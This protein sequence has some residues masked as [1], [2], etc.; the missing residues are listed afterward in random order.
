MTKKDRRLNLAVMAMGLLLWGCSGARLMMPTPNVYLNDELEFFQ[1]L[2]PELKSTQVKLFYMTDRKPEKDNKGTLRYGYGRSS[3]LAF[4]TTVVDLGR[5]MTWEEL[6]QASRTQ[7]RSKPVKLSLLDVTELI[8]GPD[9]PVPYALIDGKVV[10][11][12]ALLAQREEAI[13]AIR[14]L[15]VQQLA[16]TPRKEVFIYIH[17]YHNNFDKAAFAMAELWHF[18]GRIGVPIVYTWPSGYPGLFGYTYDRESS[19]FTIYHLRE[20]LDFI[21]GFPE[22]EKIHVIAHSRGADAAVAALR[23]LTIGSRKAGIDPKHKFK[24]HNFVLAAPDIDVNVAEQRVSGD[25]IILSVNR[26]TIYTSPED[27]AIGAANR[28]F[29]SPRGRIGTFGPEHA[30][31]NN[32]AMMEFGPSNFAIVDFPGTYDAKGRK[33]DRFGHGYF[34]NAPAVSSDLVLMLR[35]DLDPG[36]HGRPLEHVDLDFWRIPPG[37]PGMP[38]SE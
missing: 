32:R 15:L 6:L 26:F 38:S 19:E 16:R 21:A 18:L 29:R 1:D 20:V 13:Q 30:T 10:E 37:Y 36:S 34:R 28:F 9:T 5:D 25:K 31:K 27:G 17:G 35:D 7:K 3:S 8:R 22:V 12:P 14:H 33:G 24:V 23:E 4:G 2:A 11:Q